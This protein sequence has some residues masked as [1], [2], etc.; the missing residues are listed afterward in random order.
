MAISELLQSAAYLQRVPE[1]EPRVLDGRRHKLFCFAAA[2]ER[3]P[4]NLVDSVLKEEDGQGFDD[5][6]LIVV[7]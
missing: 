5:N 3:A 2:F 6:G 1:H 4:M 7:I